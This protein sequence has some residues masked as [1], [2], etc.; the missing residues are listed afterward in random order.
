[1]TSLHRPGVRFVLT[2]RCNLHPGTIQLLQGRN[3]QSAVRSGLWI[4]WL[5]GNGNS[6]GTGLASGTGAGS[7]SMV[8][9]I[10]TVQLLFSSKEMARGRF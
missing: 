1:M 10:I 7:P 6:S 2:L 9:I 5:R 4:D 3:S 8:N